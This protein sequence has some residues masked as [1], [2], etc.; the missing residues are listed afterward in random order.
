MS[1]AAVVRFGCR[2][3]RGACFWVRDLPIDQL[4]LIGALRTEITECDHSTTTRQITDK[5]GLN[6]AERLVTR[7]VVSGNRVVSIFNAECSDLET[8]LKLPEKNM[9][10]Y[11]FF[12]KQNCIHRGLGGDRDNPWSSGVDLM[13]PSTGRVSLSPNF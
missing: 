8:E 2:R 12:S 5:S 11:W 1:A 3:Q 6:H 4:T 9:L 7:K 10:A 13:D